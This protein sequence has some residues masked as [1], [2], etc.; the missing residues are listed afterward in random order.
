MADMCDL[1]RTEEVIRSDKQ[2]PRDE[3]N[4]R[5]RHRRKDN[6]GSETS[7]KKIWDKMCSA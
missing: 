1:H 3:N 6:N 2:L 5:T 4:F 7:T